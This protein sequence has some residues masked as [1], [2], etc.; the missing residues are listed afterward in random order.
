[1][2]AQT[3]PAR[4]VDGIGTLV[5]VGLGIAL[6]GAGG[7][8]LAIAFAA[9]NAFLAGIILVIAGPILLIAGAAVGGI[10]A[11]RILNLLRQE[12]KGT[13]AHA[14]IA[15]HGLSLVLASVFLIVTLAAGVDYLFR[16]P[17]DR[18][19]LAH[20][21][22]HEATFRRAV[23]MAE[24]DKKLLRVDDT[25]TEPHQPQTIGVSAARVAEYRRL[26]REAGTPRGFQV[27]KSTGGF[28]VWKPADGI[29]FFCW[30]SGSGFTSTR[31][32]GVA[33]LKKRPT[34]TFPSLD[35]ESHPPFAYRLIRGN[36][37]L[38][39]RYAAG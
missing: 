3:N 18:V 39:Y 5:G 34:K 29:H 23:Q 6:G 12:Q 26:L 21:E 4:L 37:Y 14:R 9:G 17:S 31:V 35:Q 10:Q 27:E 20:F 30:V 11:S 2:P 19:L 24:A 16:P 38:F 36:W 8:F 32:K 7:L 1:M 22:R 13:A 28:Q 33:Y 25:W 15:K